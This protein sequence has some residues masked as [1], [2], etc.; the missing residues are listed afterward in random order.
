VTPE[1]TG[2]AVA[3]TTLA[4]LPK[5]GH[6]RVARLTGRPVV[7]QRLSEMGL[8]PGT[9]VVV[10]RF[11]PLGDPIEVRVRGYALSLRREDARAVVL[12]AG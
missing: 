7:V 9:E 2:E 5:G 6:G 3:A 8:T 1:V 11:A 12:A 10:V 4:D